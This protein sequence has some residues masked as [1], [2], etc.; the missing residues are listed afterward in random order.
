MTAVLCASAET[1]AAFV[2][3]AAICVSAALWVVTR[4]GLVSAV[5]GWSVNYFFWNYP[6]TFAPTQWY[7]RIGYMAL[8]LVAAITFYGFQTSLVGRRFGLVANDDELNSR[9]GL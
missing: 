3:S 9:R 1:P 7:S 2:P 6:M 5:V 8:F 4:F